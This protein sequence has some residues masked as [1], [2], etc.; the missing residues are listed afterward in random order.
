MTEGEFALDGYDIVKAETITTPNSMTLFGPPG[1]GKSV[2]ASSIVEVPGFERTL[3]V[4]TEGGSVAVSKWY[5]QID[6]IHA[7]TAVKFTKVAE[8]LLN[9]KLVEPTSGLPYQCVIIDTLDKAQQRQVQ[10][11]DKDPESKSNSYYKWGAIKIWTEKI[12]DFFHQAN[13]LVIFVLHEDVDDKNPARVMTTVMLQGKSQRDFPSVSDVVGYVNMIRA[14][15]DGKKVAK[16][17]ADFR[18]SD[19]LVSKQRFADKLDGVIID[20]DMTKIFQKIEPG[21]FK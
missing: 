21:R 9:G 4:D 20:P 19:K 3:L 13:F 17:A 11:Y 16:R 2:L 10:V 18:M 14:E 7:N 6:V 12:A 1:K 5:P 15:E 8:A